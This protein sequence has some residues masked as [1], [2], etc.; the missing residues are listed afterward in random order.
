MHAAPVPFRPRPAAVPMT[1]VERHVPGDGRSRLRGVAVA[2]LLLGT[3]VMVGIVAWYGMAQVGAA[4]M[5]G[6]I[7]LPATALVYLTQIGLSAQAWR[8]VVPR[9]RPPPWLMFQA[10][11]VREAVNCLLPVA[12]IGGGIAGIRLLTRTAGLAAVP[13]GASL[14]V[15]V[16]VE[17]LTLVLFLISG[18]AAVWM[19]STDNTLL[20]SAWVW[21]SLGV[22]AGAVAAFVVAQ[23]LGL[24]KLVEAVF[25]RV[26]P[27]SLAGKPGQIHGAMMTI[28]ARPGVLVRAAAW[29]L[30]SWSFGAAEVWIL[31][32]ALGHPV[33]PAAAYGIESLGLAARTAF[34]VIPGGLAAQEAGFL[35]VGLLV[36]LPPSISLAISMLKR[37]RELAVNIP[38]VLRWQWLEG[39]ALFRA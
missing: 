12:N 4:V 33:S 10:R 19:I 16:T 30:L 31:S 15:D 25:R 1:E 26:F 13:A 28:Y 38:G 11:W 9:P 35:L 2:A 3:T 8:T 17:A 29:H 32:R 21:T 7:V 39:R 14:T 18:V 37:L 6:I 22:A 24:V 34:F 20:D 5:E 23:R 36:G 27:A